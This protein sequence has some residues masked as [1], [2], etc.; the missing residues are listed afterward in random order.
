MEDLTP[1]LATTA[2]FPSFATFPTGV[3]P[4][5]SHA[6]EVN[7]PFAQLTASFGAATS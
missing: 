2:T 4:A 3:R 6:H 5:A 1:V 7:D